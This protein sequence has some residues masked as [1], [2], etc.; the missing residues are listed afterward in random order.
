[1]HG[2]HIAHDLIA[3]ASRHG[4]VK[5]I[6]I[7]L[8][9]AAPIT[10]QEL[11]SSIKDHVDW[12]VEFTSREA[13][14]VCRSCGSEMRPGILERGHDYVILQCHCGSRD[15]ELKEGGDIRLSSVVVD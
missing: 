10:R 7:E 8:G 4:D 15:V 3:E 5:A 13:R 1:M 2:L 9:E 6:K 14:A 12:G 11:L